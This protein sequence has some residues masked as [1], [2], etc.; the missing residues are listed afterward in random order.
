M[1]FSILL[2]NENYEQTTTSVHVSSAWQAQVLY[3][4]MREKKQLKSDN[5]KC[6]VHCAPATTLAQDWANK[7]KQRAINQ[8]HKNTKSEDIYATK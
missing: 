4:S 6:I 7:T 3:K 1:A 5:D 2:D 8:T